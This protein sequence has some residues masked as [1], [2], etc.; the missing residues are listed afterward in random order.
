MGVSLTDSPPAHAAQSGSPPGGASGPADVPAPL[1]RGTRA[2]FVFLLLWMGSLTALVV[3]LWNRYE[4]HDDATAL[5]AWVLA[6]MCFYLTLCNTFVPLP[7]AWI[8]L[9]AARPDYALAPWSP[10]NILIV[11]AAATLATIVANLTE[12]HLL[13]YLLHFRWGARLRR[14]PAVTWAVAWFERA[15]F[16]LLTLLAFIPLPVDAVRWLAI[17]RGYSRTR[18]ALA[19]LVGRGPRYVIFAVCSVM[20]A[21]STRQI[22]EIQLGLLVLAA[23]G[24]V[25][26]RTL[27]R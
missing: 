25:I 14:A 18:Y 27:R 5:H 11:A 2:W 24:R 1:P 26:W 22:L 19:Y 7:T 23:A 13:A 17:L 9:L 3:L 15:P 8:V 10:L 16:Q 6:L 21:L 12:Y 20:F 4:R